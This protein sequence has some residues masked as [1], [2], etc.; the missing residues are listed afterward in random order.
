[1]DE[2]EQHYRFVDL[3]RK[4]LIGNWPTLRH[5]QKVHGFPAGKKLGGNMRVWT[6]REV[7]EWLASRPSD[8]KIIPPNAR[9][10]GRPRKQPQPPQAASI[11]G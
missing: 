9:R 8:I 7:N 6:A 4:G 1:M 10:P 2:I 11:S 5:L 3:K